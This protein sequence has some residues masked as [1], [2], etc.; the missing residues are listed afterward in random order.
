M[1]VFPFID[2]GKTAES[3]EQEL[4]LLKEYAYDFEKN[5]LL[6]DADGRTFLV[7]GREALR[8]WIFKALFTERFHY[9]AYSAAYGSEWK[10]QLTGRAMNGEIIKLELERFIVEALMVN[11]YIKRLDNFVFDNTFTGMTVSFDVTSVYGADTILIPVRE[12]KV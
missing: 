10:E 9:I 1:S 2:A 5:E 11:P 3:A 8:I 6:L 12:V 4:P 7:E